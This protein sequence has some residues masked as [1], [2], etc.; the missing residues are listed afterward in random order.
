MHVFLMPKRWNKKAYPY[1][2]LFENND[3]YIYQRLGTYEIPSDWVALITYNTFWTD[4]NIIATS[5]VVDYDRSDI[6]KITSEW[7]PT[8]TYF[9]D[10]ELL[11]R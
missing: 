1:I 3:F 4:G 11:A 7:E 8:G 9:I 2:G 10:R 6:S 5:K